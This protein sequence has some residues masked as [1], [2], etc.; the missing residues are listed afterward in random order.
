MNGLIWLSIGIVLFAEL[1]AG[2]LCLSDP[3]FGLKETLEMMCLT[4]LIVV[5]IIAIS[6]CF[7]RG[8]N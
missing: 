2:L 6:F 8:L 1:L 5:L 3:F 4:L 7:S